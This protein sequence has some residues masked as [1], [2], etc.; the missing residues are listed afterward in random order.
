MMR[1]PLRCVILAPGQDVRLGEAAPLRLRTWGDFVFPR[2]LHRTFSR[3]GREQLGSFDSVL[4]PYASSL[5]RQRDAR[6]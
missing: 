2:Q 1:A 6:P 3:R 5:A 4:G